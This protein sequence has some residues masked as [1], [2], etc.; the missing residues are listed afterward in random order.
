M[1]Q[2]RTHLRARGDAGVMLRWTIRRNPAGQALTVCD[3]RS[4]VA[5]QRER[6]SY[7]VGKSGL[8][9]INPT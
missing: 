5:V 2:A 8:A 1:R 4:C 9:L 6:L 3:Q 7:D